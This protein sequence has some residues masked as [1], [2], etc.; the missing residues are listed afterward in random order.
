M[1]SDDMTSRYFQVLP[2]TSSDAWW[3]RACMLGVGGGLY[4]VRNG[5]VNDYALTFNVPLRAD[6][7][8]IYFN[9]NAPA[10]QS[11]VSTWCCQSLGPSLY[12][13]FTR[14]DATK[15]L[16]RVWSSSANWALVK[17]HR[18]P[19]ITAATELHAVGSYGIISRSSLTFRLPN[20]ELELLRCN[21]S[22]ERK[23]VKKLLARL[24]DDSLKI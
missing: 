15:Q 3:S 12:T 11:P 19:F 5:T 16:C 24:S 21:V 9:W 23:N 10:D 7:T 4:Y 20:L 1:L 6:I 18:S 13:R 2:G 8:D 17:T 14:P 22:S